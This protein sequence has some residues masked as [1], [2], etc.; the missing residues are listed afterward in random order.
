MTIKPESDEIDRYNYPA[1]VGD[2][3]FL[4]FRSVLPVGSAAPDVAVTVAASGE[5]ARLCDFWHDADLVVE[6]G[7]LT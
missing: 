2:D 3:D 5:P 4:A 6:F 7:S 1:F